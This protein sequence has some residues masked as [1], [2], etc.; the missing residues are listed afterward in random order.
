MFITL[1]LMSWVSFVSCAVNA[2]FRRTGSGGDRGAIKQPIVAER[3]VVISTDGNKVPAVCVS[4]HGG[5]E[6][7]GLLISGVCSSGSSSEYQLVLSI[8]ATLMIKVVVTCA[9]W[10]PGEGSD[11]KCTSVSSP[12]KGE[13]A[14]ATVRVDLRVTWAASCVCDTANASEAS[15]E[16]L[17]RLLAR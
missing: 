12:G 16:S 3:R 7:P 14:E 2:T 10:Q 8:I 13:V 4:P 6:Y 11:A 17:S 15:P 9:K 5:V 1:V